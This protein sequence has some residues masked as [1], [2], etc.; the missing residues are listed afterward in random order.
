MSM[1]QLDHL[2]TA[3]LLKGSVHVH[4]AEADNI[5]NHFLGQRHGYRAVVRHAALPEAIF[6]FKQEM[7]DALHGILAAEAHQV[8]DTKSRLLGLRQAEAESYSWIALLV[9][10]SLTEL[11]S[12]Y[13]SSGRRCKHRRIDDFFET[14]AYDIPR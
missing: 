8:I 14:R 11:A 3:Q 4:E 5:A 13:C 6:Q 1:F 10:E 9:R 12:L 7:C 2:V